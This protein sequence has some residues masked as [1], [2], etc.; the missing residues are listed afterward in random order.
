LNRNWATRPAAFA[1]AIIAMALVVAACGGG[2]KTAT[3]VPTTTSTTNARTARTAAFRACMSK[4]GVNLPANAGFGFGF[5]GRGGGGAGAGSTGSVPTSRSI[6]STTLPA[7]VTEQQY[8]AA[9]KACASTLPTGGANLANNPQFSAYYNCL[10]S[11][12][13]ANNETTLPPLSST[14]GGGLGGLFGRGGAGAGASGETTTTNPSL[15][16]AMTHCIALRP[17]FG[18]GTTTTT[19]A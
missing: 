17:T 2:S 14:G 10:N 6:P 1:G 16:A 4:N 13:S 9:E 12:L 11:Y 18:G 3:A 5:G 7:G 19:T 15:Q 8:Q